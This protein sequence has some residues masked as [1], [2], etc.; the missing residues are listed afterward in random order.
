MEFTFNFKS[1]AV[2]SGKKVVD[3]SKPVISLLSTFNNFKLNRTAMQALEVGVG[4]R[5]VLLDIGEQAPNLDNRFFI[6]KDFE[7]KGKTFG[8]KITT[9]QSF[10]YSVVYGAM[11]A[12]DLGIT[13]ITPQSLIEMGLLHEKS[14][15]SKS[16]QYIAAQ[17]ADMDMELYANGEPQ[18]VSSGVERVLYRIC[19]FQFEDHTPRVR[20]EGSEGSDNDVE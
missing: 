10:T 7:V 4:D 1:A 11:L 15:D 12:Q 20:G 6:C 8:S 19:N 16:T 3:E 13:S 18:E 17:E 14:E 5:V 2:K 9:G